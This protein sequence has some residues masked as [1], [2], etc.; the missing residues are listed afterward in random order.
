MKKAA[1]ED[2]SFSSKVRASSN[3]LFL[4]LTETEYIRQWW[5]NPVTG[6]AQEGGELKFGFL[7]SDNHVLVYIDI[8]NPHNIQWTVRKDTAYNGEWK[9]TT[10]AFDLEAVTDITSTL[11]VT[12]IGLH[13]QLGAYNESVNGWERVLKQLVLLTESLE[14]LSNVSR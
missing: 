7:D 12:H 11:H 6:S 3:T 1:N 13:P 2:Y 4:A 8:V 10:L 5:E 9:G 14:K